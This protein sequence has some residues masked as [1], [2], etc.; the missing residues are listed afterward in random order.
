MEYVKKTEKNGVKTYE[1]DEKILEVWGNISFLICKCFETSR[2]SDIQTASL[3]PWR[4]HLLTSHSI[5]ING[6]IDICKWK[7]VK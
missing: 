4:A 3:F 7:C 2:Q 1:S 5:K 6:Q